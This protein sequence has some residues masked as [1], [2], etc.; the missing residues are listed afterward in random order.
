MNGP[1]SFVGTGGALLGAAAG[2]AALLRGEKISIVQKALI[3]VVLLGAPGYIR[4]ARRPAPPVLIPAAAGPSGVQPVPDAGH[5]RRDIALRILG[6]EGT[7]TPARF[8]IVEGRLQGY[9]LRADGSWDAMPGHG[10]TGRW[11]S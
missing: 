3:A 5:L 1:V 6:P 8:R 11:Q 9:T 4:R 2:T 7:M 10:H